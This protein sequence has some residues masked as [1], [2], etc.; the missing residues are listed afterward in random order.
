MEAK[1]K[2]Q[3]EVIRSDAEIKTKARGRGM[4]D[5]HTWDELGNPLKGRP[6][7]MTFSHRL[8]TFPLVE[9]FFSLSLSPFPDDSFISTPRPLAA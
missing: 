8:T 3:P 2:L 5:R 7:V 6:G 4:W 9:V 1:I